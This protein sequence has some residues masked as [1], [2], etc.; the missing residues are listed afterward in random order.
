MSNTAIVRFE[1][2]WTPLQVVIWMRAFYK[3]RCMRAS[4]RSSASAARG[5]GTDVIRTVFLVAF[6][7]AFRLDF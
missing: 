6:A 1:A 3:S 7:R 5:V 4:N 2:R